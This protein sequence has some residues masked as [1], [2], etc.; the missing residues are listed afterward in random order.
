MR[1]PTKPPVNQDSK[2]ELLR[3]ARKL[4]AEKGFD[5]TSVKDLADEAGVNVS[6]VSYF[7]GGK[8]ALYVACLEE[9]GRK[10]LELAVRVLQPPKSAE[11]FRVRLTLFIEELIR[12][13]IEESEITN[14]L[15]RDCVMNFERIQG[16]F[17]ESFLKVFQSLHDFIQQGQK[18]GILRKEIS[19]LIASQVFFGAITHTARMDKLGAQFFNSSLHDEKVRQKFTSQ[20]V[21]IAIRSL[22]VET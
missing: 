3:A 8:E 4:F 17:K 5:G 16:V 1:K 6:L 14:I 20:L 21:E 2:T 18:N 12:V 10:V 9:A 7:F 19:P 11:E 13:H 22:G 15:Q